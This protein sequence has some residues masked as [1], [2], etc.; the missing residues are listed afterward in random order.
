MNYNC[1]VAEF[2]ASAEHRSLRSFGTAGVGSFAVSPI[3][4]L[5]RPEAMSEGRADIKPKPGFSACPAF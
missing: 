5:R 2:S 4:G 1:E 3:N